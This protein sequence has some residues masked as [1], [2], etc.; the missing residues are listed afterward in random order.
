M[1][2]CL[3]VCVSQII[4]CKTFKAKIVF[5]LNISVVMSLTDISP[6]MAYWQKLTSNCCRNF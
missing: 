6:V 2:V 5:V 4:N 1:S 3:S